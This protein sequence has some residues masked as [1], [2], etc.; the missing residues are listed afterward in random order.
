[1]VKINELTLTVSSPETNGTCPILSLLFSVGG[2]H[3]IWHR[4]AFK[5]GDLKLIKSHVKSDLRRTN[6]GGFIFLF[7]I[8]FPVKMKMPNFSIFRFIV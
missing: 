1:M 6:S 8:C 2:N 4:D 7:I 5:G 3:K